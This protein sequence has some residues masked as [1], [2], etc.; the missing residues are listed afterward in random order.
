ME[1]NWAY[2]MQYKFESIDEPLSRKKFTMRQKLRKA[3]KWAN[4]LESLVEDNEL[5]CL[6]PISS[7]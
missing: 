1:R 2:A 3:A 7:N 6:N 4:F 5:V